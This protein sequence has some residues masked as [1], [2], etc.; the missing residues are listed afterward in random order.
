MKPNSTF[1]NNDKF[2]GRPVAC[3]RSTSTTTGSTCQATTDKTVRK[4][5][6]KAEGTVKKI[7]LKAYSTVKKSTPKSE[8]TVTKVT[9]VVEDT[10]KKNTPKAE[11]TVTTQKRKDITLDTTPTERTRRT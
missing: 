11:D 1:N 4:N 6:Q 7:M 5:T 3:R 8:D 2:K 9:R 10:V